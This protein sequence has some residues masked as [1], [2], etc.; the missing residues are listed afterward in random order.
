MVGV[1]VTVD[2]TEAVCD[3]VID[4]VVVAD[5]DQDSALAGAHSVAMSRSDREDESIC[6]R[7]GGESA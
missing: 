2:D 5:E 4:A 7:K 3:A 1:D 6:R